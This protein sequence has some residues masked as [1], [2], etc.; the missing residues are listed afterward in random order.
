MKSIIQLL[1]ITSVASSI[2]FYS[3]AAESLA[4]SEIVSPSE[5]VPDIC[6]VDPAYTKSSSQSVCK[7]LTTFSLSQEGQLASDSVI[8]TRYFKL[9]A[10]SNRKCLALTKSTG[11][12]VSCTSAESNIFYVNN[13][14]R[15][16]YFNIVI[17]GTE[18]CLDREHC[19]S[20][21]SNLRYSS[22]GHCGAHNWNILHD[23]K[24]TQDGGRNCIHSLSDTE[25]D[26]RH[27]K[28]GGE[29]F[30][31]LPLGDRFFLK[32]LKHGDCVS[33]GKFVDCGCAPTFY[34]TGVPRY[35][36][37]RHFTHGDTQG[38]ICLNRESCHSST[39][40]LRFSE[41]SHC[42]ALHWSI[43][44]D[45][46]G[47]DGMRNCIRREGDGKAMLKHC[48]DGHD[49]L[50]YIFVPPTGQHQVHKKLQAAAEE[51]SVLTTQN[52]PFHD[53][54][55][56]NYLN[57]DL[58]NGFHGIKIFKY[59]Q[60]NTIE[61][62]V[63]HFL[64]TTLAFC[65]EFYNVQY[66]VTHIHTN[67][68]YNTD[69]INRHGIDD[70]ITQLQQ[71]PN[72]TVAAVNYR[73]GGVGN[74]QRNSYDGLTAEFVTNTGPRA[75]VPLPA[76]YH[77]Q[78]VDRIVNGYLRVTHNNWHIYEANYGSTVQLFMYNILAWHTAL[79]WGQGAC[80]NNYRPFIKSVD[81]TEQF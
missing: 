72:E 15:P 8:P 48:S 37:I 34:T 80:N 44:G 55:L 60:D 58:V 71:Y 18:Y 36:K 76:Q 3:T 17:F 11:K 63:V 7:N 53:P 81:V 30:N 75:G 28:N 61:L 2:L 19:H 9:Q 50:T 6:P 33:A 52:R 27:C 57:I 21:S 45:A 64:P 41:C 42:G 12:Y 59:S 16:D 74:Y 56:H 13:R 54:N 47:E 23:G 62:E 73:Y 69:Q 20:G 68:P 66:M 32:S 65:T 24:V 35:Y 22:C 51:A 1:L 43:E 31:L 49:E 26:V 29:R 78:V 25:V 70:I 46:V 10:Q 79:Y 5:L 40:N 14:D 67:I 77:Y 4:S 38:N 39:S